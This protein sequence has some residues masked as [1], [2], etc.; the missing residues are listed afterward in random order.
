[1]DSVSTM[2]Q[3]GLLHTMRFPVRA[4]AVA[5]VVVKEGGTAGGIDTCSPRYDD[6]GGGMTSRRAPRDRGGTKIAA[7]QQSQ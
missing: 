4:V 1:M 5:V 3:H 2:C 6:R 7:V